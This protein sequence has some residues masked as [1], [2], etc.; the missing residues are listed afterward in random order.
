MLPESRR[1]NDLEQ[2]APQYSDNPAK[3]NKR[4]VHGNAPEIKTPFKRPSTA[5]KWGERD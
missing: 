1:L 3:M 2:V 4:D 5:Q